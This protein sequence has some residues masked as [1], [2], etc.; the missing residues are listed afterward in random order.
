VAAIG[1]VDSSAI[2]S[3][4]VV[5]ASNLLQLAQEQLPVPP[6]VYE[7]LIAAERARA[8]RNREVVQSL[9]E[10][11]VLNVTGL[12]AAVDALTTDRQ[13]VQLAVDRQAAWV[14]ADDEKLGRCAAR[15]GLTVLT[16]PGYL[17]LLLER[18]LL[19]RRRY[20]QHVIN[21][22]R[23]ARITAEVRDAYLAR[24]IHEHRS[25]S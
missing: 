20:N 5:N 2:V 25:Q 8:H 10:T 7:E 21:L 17:F 9:F 24:I 6:G 4:V 13:V 11:K 22:C 1:V 15:K 19:Q 12:S 3:L 18:G 23:S 16:S 14:L